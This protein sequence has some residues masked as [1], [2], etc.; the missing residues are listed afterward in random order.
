MP[1]LVVVLFFLLAQKLYNTI[2]REGIQ[3]NS[4]LDKSGLNHK[5]I[6]EKIPISE[7]WAEYTIPLPHNGMGNIKGEEIDIELA[8][9]VSS[10]AQWEVKDIEFKEFTKE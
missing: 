8:S 1:F 7:E 2:H 10:P 9:L 5:I 4:I 3:L 6:K